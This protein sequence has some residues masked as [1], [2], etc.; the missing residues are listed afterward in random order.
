MTRKTRIIIYSIF[1]FINMSIVIALFLRDNAYKLP[2]FLTLHSFWS[3][4][5]YFLAC[6]ILE[7]RAEWKSIYSE[8][9]LPF[10]QNTYFKFSFTFTCFITTNFYLYA[11]LQFNMIFYLPEYSRKP[12]LFL[13]N[14]SNKL[15]TSNSASDSPIILLNPVH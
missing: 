1:T 14:R 2:F 9:F 3:N 8:R 7:I 10:M 5:F 12:L 11:L 13:S 4:C 15:S 6:L